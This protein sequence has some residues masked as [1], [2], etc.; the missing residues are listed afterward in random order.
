M[1]EGLISLSQRI[2][3][4]FLTFSIKSIFL[5]VHTSY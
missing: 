5:F 2:E 4:I 1:T 3:N